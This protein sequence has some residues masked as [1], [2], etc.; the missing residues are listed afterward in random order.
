MQMQKYI[1]TC[2]SLMLNNQA[3]IKQKDLQFTKQK[4]KFLVWIFKDFFQIRFKSKI[5]SVYVLCNTCH[6]NSHN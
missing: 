1:S 5:L 3:N 6:K 4:V 2:F